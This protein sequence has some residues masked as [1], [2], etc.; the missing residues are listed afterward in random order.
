MQPLY[1][2]SLNKHRNESPPHFTPGILAVAGNVYAQQHAS[3]FKVIPLGVKGG[4]DEGNL[5]A[6]M[7]AVEG[8]EQYVCLDAGTV[9]DG[10]QK[11]V[12]NGLFKQPAI[13]V[14]KNSIK[15]YLISHPHLDHVA[16]L[17]MNSPA[18]T[19]KNI[20]GTTATI[21]ALQKALFQLGKLGQF[22]RCR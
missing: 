5:S 13:A 8:T 11:A 6:Y 15:G 4:L 16:G 1:F 20:Y 7:L 19:A 17:I 3:S 9:Y 10:I 2:C 14:L 22:R 18:D 12:D 21:N